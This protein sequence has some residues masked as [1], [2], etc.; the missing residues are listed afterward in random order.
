MRPA[1]VS[2]GLQR[3]RRLLGGGSIPERSG[4][5]AAVWKGAVNARPSDRAQ[6]ARSLDWRLC[7]QRPQNRFHLSVTVLRD[8]HRGGR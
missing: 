4:R 7:F 2:G 6:L 1:G 8:R 5:G 3:A